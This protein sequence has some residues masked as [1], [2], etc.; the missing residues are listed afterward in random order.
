[1]CVY[2]Y[3]CVCVRARA[4]AS[5]VDWQHQAVAMTTTHKDPLGASATTDGQCKAWAA[6]DT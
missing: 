5:C 3:V 2:A 4:C 6:P 1:M